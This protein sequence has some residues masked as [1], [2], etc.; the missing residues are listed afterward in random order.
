MH[1]HKEGYTESSR[2]S[3]NLRE[4][5]VTCW[6]RTILREGFYVDIWPKRV[7]SQSHPRGNG[8]YTNL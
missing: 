2:S 4:A 3:V 1:M 7:H 5:I 8:G 6:S